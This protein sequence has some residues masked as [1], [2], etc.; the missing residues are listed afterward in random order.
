M[1][2]DFNRWSLPLLIL[3]IQGLVFVVLLFS[4][5][6]KKKHLS[7]LFLGLIL[8]LTCYAQICYTLGF[9]GWY[10]EFRTTKIN[11]FLIN[12]G[13]ALA[14]LIFLYIKSITT[15]NF[16]FK[17]SY[18]WHFALAFVIIMYRFSIYTYDALQPGFN[19]TQNGI[20]KIELDEAYIQSILSYIETPFMLLYLAFTFQ[21][22]YSYRKK[23]IQYFSNTYKLELNWILSFLILFSLSFLYGTIQ[24]IIGSRFMDLGYQQRWW[25]N[26]FMAIITLYVGIKGYFTDTTKLNKLDFTFTPKTIGIPEDTN[27]F[28]EKS[29]S[30]NDIDTVKYLMETDKAY[31]NPELNLSDLAQL[32]KMTRGQLSETINSGFNKNFNDF[33]NEY[34]VNAFKSMLKEDKHKQLSLLGIA[35][36]CGFNSK[37]T[38]NR[39]FK[40]LTN[41]S[42][43]E[44]LKSQLN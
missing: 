30:N 26:L 38:F 22:F 28:E 35:Q 24:D 29:I 2:P 9:L 5:Y 43:T 12:I 31:L 11:Y 37:A 13:V 41:Y 15:S 20:L 10:N 36:E 1:F 18:W 40:K 42:P 8:L 17:T 21:L 19:D 34:R 27:D 4:R 16:R 14:P 32:A 33:V 23:I 39:V 7:D 44:Y 25:L 3:V 6:F